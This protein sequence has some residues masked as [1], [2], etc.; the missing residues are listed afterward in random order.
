MQLQV[1]ETIQYVDRDGWH[2][3]ARVLRI[4]EPL[5]RVLV[6]YGHDVREW[7][8]FSSL[9]LTPGDHVVMDGEVVGRVGRVDRDGDVLIQAGDE[10]ILVYRNR[11]R[12]S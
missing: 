5:Q 11:L 3:N 7:I 8:E 2:C 1:G 12:K 10:R 9:Y 6:E 4:D